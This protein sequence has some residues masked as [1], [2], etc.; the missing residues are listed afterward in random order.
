MSISSKTKKRR[1]IRKKA[2]G[3]QYKVKRAQQGTPKFPIDPEKA[4]PDSAEKR[5][6]KERSE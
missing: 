1:A 4:G 2:T 3:K 6:A 5:G